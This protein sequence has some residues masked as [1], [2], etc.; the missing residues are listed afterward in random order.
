MSKGHFDV[1][2][3]FLIH[4]VVNN[5]K[6]SLLCLPDVLTVCEVSHCFAC[7][8]HTQA[9]IILHNTHKRHDP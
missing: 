9:L 7:Y 3:V 2:K 6:S 4:C 5:T 8:T 1:P